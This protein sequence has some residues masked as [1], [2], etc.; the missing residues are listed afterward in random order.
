MRLSV[1]NVSSQKSARLISCDYE[2]LSVQKR[3]LL[4]QVNKFTALQAIAGA[5][6]C[7]RA[8]SNRSL[9]ENTNEFLR[10]W[11]FLRQNASPLISTFQWVNTGMMF[12]LQ[13][14]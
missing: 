11:P 6:F 12:D 13:A 3:D 4:K 5:K 2:D 9:R 1:F 8:S 7:V 10:K 14:C